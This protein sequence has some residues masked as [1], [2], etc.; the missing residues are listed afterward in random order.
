MTNQTKFQSDLIL[1]LATTGPK[2]K[3]QSATFS[4][5]DLILGL[6]T[7]G[8]KLK[9]QSATFSIP[10]RDDIFFFCGLK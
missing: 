5:P 9:T 6:A 7:T 3:T 8:P 4:I 1:G 2:L 10:R